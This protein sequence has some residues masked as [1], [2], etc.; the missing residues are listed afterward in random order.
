[1]MNKI[2]QIVSLIFSFLFISWLILNLKFSSSQ[3][4]PEDQIQKFD[5]NDLIINN[6]RISVVGEEPPEFDSFSLVLSNGQILHSLMAGDGET[7]ILLVHGADRKTQNSEYWKPFLPQL[8]KY[9]RVVA[10]DMLGYGAS[11]PGAETPMDI[12]IPPKQ[13]A[14][15]LLY[16]ISSLQTSFP[17]IKQVVLFARSYGGRVVAELLNNSTTPEVVSKISQVVLIAPAIGG[18]NV[19]TLPDR[20]KNIPYLVFWAQDDPVVPATRL[21]E[22][23][24]VFSHN[25]KKFS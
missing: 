24:Q 14:I 6:G 4:N 10:V 20:L 13:Q 1:M 11:E 25:L 18:S 19:L 15:S 3:S 22:L 16:L 23:K 2:V 9:G 7:L 12:Q 5:Q 21:W 17:E 8:S